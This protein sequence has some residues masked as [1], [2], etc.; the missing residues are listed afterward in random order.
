M[1]YHL[2]Y[3]FSSTFGAFNVF[4]YLTFRTLCAGLTALI[5]SLALGPYFIK[6]LASRQMEQNIR[7]DGPERGMKRGFEAGSRRTGRE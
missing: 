5:I 1:L 6:M 4:R 3:S 2:L 7:S